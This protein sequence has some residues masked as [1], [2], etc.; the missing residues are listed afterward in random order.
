MFDIKLRSCVANRCRAWLYDDDKASNLRQ[1]IVMKYRR[2]FISIGV[3]CKSTEQASNGQ[4]PAISSRERERER[5]R[6]TGSPSTGCGC[7]SNSYKL[8]CS[9]KPIDHTERRLPVYCPMPQV[10]LLCAVRLH[11]TGHR[12]RNRSRC[13]KTFSLVTK[14][15]RNQQCDACFSDSSSPNP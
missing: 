8:R 5:E 4:R 2:F 1:T 7:G 12:H 6:E 3:C 13:L 9:S 11:C 14:K 10:L 15:L